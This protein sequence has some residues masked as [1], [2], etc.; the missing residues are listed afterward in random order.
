MRNVS[1]RRSPAGRHCGA[2]FVAAALL[3]SCQHQTPEQEL[4]DKADPAGS[5]ISTLQM[6][7]EK[8]LANS[9]PTS[10]VKTTCQAADDD[11]R[12]AAEQAANSKARPDMRDPL[13]RMISQAQVAGKSLRQAVTANDRPEVARQDARLAALR[14]QFEAWKKSVSPP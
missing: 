6:A 3:A 8:W 14:K 11:L 13:R 10:F 5:W 12:D 4:L 7:G 9:I 1:S 2:I